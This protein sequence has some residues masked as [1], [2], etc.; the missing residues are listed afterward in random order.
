[1]RFTTILLL[2]IVALVQGKHYMLYS[3]PASE[4][5]LYDSYFGSKHL[6]SSDFA[7]ELRNG[8]KTNNSSM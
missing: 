5:Y 6:C 1:M 3:K 2:F 8:S 4:L 7:L